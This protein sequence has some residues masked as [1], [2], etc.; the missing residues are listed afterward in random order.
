[1]AIL[2]MHD[3]NRDDAEFIK[4]LPIIKNISTDNRNFKKAVNW[5]LRQ[6]GKGN[7][8]LNKKA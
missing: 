5:A 7:C 2:S 1:M 8:I 6:I 4:F 3:K